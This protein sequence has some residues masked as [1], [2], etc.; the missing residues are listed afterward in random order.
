MNIHPIFVH[1]PIAFFTL[2]AIAELIRFKVF[3]KQ[4]YWFYIK[5][6]LVTIGVFFALFLTIPTGK[7]AAGIVTNGNPDKLINTHALFAITTTIIFT[8]A[9]FGYGLEWLKRTNKTLPAFL[10]KLQVFITET[11]AIIV[12]AFVGLICVSIT[13]ALGGSIVYGPESEP[14][15]S[16]VYHL[17]VNR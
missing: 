9:A 1:F 6:F 3:T 15:S 16:F 14:F 12:I 8:I 5:A 4:S 7:I 17:L 2:Y 10:L 11:P 13:G